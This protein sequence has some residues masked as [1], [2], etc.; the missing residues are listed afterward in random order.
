MKLTIVPSD[1]AVCVDGA[2]TLHLSWEGT[3]ANIHAVQWKDESGWIEYNDGTPNEDI[4]VLPAWTNN[5]IAAWTVANTPLPPTPAT[6]EENKSIAMSILR[7]TDWT[8]IPSVSDPALSNP[9]LANKLAFDQYR[10]AMRQYAVYPVEGDI[11]WP[12]IPAEDWVKV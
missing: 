3:P 9:Y 1:N 12:T 11:T 6:A 2:G 10:D 8:Q 4:T 7:Q 5:A